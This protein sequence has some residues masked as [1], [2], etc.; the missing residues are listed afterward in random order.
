MA[1]A[2]KN[3][4]KQL[5][6][7]PYAPLLAHIRSV[8]SYNYSSIA[9]A[10][11]VNP[12]PF[13]NL[14]KKTIGE[15]DNDKNIKSPKSSISERQTAVGAYQIIKKN[16][17]PFANQ[18][19]L[20]PNDLFSQENQDLMAIAEIE[21]VIK[22]FRE[23]INND[24][25]EASEALCKIWAGLRCIYP[26][27]QGRDQGGK[28]PKRNIEKGM[29]YYAGVSINATDIKPDRADTLHNIL[30]MINPNIEEPTASQGITP[31]SSSTFVPPPPPPQLTE[32]E[33]NEIYSSSLAGIESPFSPSSAIP[34]D[35]YLNFIQN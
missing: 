26:I 35:Q 12:N 19:G 3:T 5:G 18:A 24:I 7:N 10:G 23:G 32:A 21:R 4:L 29:S 11:S 8:E 33:I 34:E 13:G 6:I 1:V 30:F 9:G 14:T 20:G 17:I 25:Q 15:I 28:Y 16:L 22:S 2:S 27:A 31:V